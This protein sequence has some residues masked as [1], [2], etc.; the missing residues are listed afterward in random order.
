MTQATVIAAVN[1]AVNPSVNNAV[2]AAAAQSFTHDSANPVLTSNSLHF[3]EQL[4]IEQEAWALG[5][6]TNSNNLLYEILAKCY[7]KYEVMCLGTAEANALHTQLNDYITMYGVAVNKKSHTLHKIVKCVFGADRRRVSAY[8][9]VLRTAAFKKI[10]SSNIADFITCNGGVEE[11]RLSKNGNALSA[12]QKAEAAKTTV[13]TV[14]LAQVSNEA[15]SQKVDAANVGQQVVFIATQQ[16]NGAFVINAVIE[17]DTAVNAAL[18]AYYSA[19]KKALVM[20][21]TGQVVANNDA[22]LNEAISKI[23]A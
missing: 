3:I 4:K 12:K 8:S 2:V 18:A 11:I 14:E 6:Y 7:A 22:L 16:A 15:I 19:H 20:Q 9:I 21:S 17:G 5:A 23:A 1:A 13:T 10:S